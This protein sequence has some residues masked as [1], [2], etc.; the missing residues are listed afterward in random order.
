MTDPTSRIQESLQ[1][2]LALLERPTGDEME[3]CVRLLE[4]C[5]GRMEELQRIV[6]AAEDAESMRGELGRIRGHLNRLALLMRQ[7][8]EF[9]ISCALAG[10][11]G[12]PG[13]T[14]HGTSVPDL[15]IRRL[16]IEG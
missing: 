13:Y 2:A 9:Q 14:P 1:Q 10:A 5:V 4:G 15:S 11:A 16:R 8:V 6:A 12:A 3:E 7:A